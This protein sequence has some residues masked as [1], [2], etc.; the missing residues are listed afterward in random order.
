MS[1]DI[2]LPKSLLVNIKTNENVPGLIP[3]PQGS[4]GLTGWINERIADGFITV[5]GSGLT[6]GDKGD[7]VVSGGASAWTIDTGVVT[8]AKIANDA[9]TADK[10]ANT[11]VSAG[12]YTNADITVDAQG[13]IT[14]AANGSG[15]G[16]SFSFTQD[17]LTDG[18]FDSAVDRFGG[19]ATVL[20]NPSAGTYNF[21]VQSGAY[22]NAIDIFGDNTTLNASQEMVIVV[23]NSANSVD[24][25]FVVQL[26]DANNSA[27]VDQQVTSTNHTQS[28]AGNVTTITVPGL[29]GFGGTGYRIKLR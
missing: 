4:V 20:T 10:L 16:G 1:V 8:T 13:R 2:R 3:N 6:D 5:T 25:T 17:A 18:N 23:D 11:S 29:N 12:S 22:L 21:E 28:T 7:I 9:V 19:T 15:G 24:R 27:L 26:Y 14:A